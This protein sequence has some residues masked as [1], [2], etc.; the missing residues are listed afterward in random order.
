MTLLDLLRLDLTASRGR[1]STEPRASTRPRG[2]LLPRRHH[3]HQRRGGDAAVHPGPA[4]P[5]LHLHGGGVLCEPFVA[6]RH[7]RG[8]RRPWQGSQGRRRPEAWAGGGELLASVFMSSVVVFGVFCSCGGKHVFRAA[9][10]CLA[11]ELARKFR[12]YWHVLVTVDGAYNIHTYRRVELEVE[13]EVEMECCPRGQR[14]LTFVVWQHSLHS[15]FLSASNQE[16]TSNLT[17]GL[18]SYRRDMCC[19]DG[20]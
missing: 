2:E 6:G 14:R 11:S 15:Q 7:P 10:L 13:V 1:Y 5:V 12:L 16:S 4:G 8:V 9:A 20:V 3:R 17:C 18:F 19:G